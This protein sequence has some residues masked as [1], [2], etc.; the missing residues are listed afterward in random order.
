MQNSILIIFCPGRKAEEKVRSSTQ[1]CQLVKLL[2]L[3]LLRGPQIHLSLS[4]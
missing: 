1:S 2:Y 4:P 3:I